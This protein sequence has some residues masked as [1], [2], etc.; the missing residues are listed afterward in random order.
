[1]KLTL[2]STDIL[3]DLAA[4]DG[5]MTVRVWRGVDVSGRAIYAYIACIAVHQDG[6]VEDCEADLAEIGLPPEAIRDHAEGRAP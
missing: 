1:M 2:E 5:A 6:P 4:P 3:L